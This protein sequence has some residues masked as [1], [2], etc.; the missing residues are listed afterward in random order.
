LSL[1][2]GVRVGVDVAATLL[3]VLMWARARRRLHPTW[4]LLGAAATFSALLFSFAIRPRLT[5]PYLEPDLACIALVVG[6]TAGTP[7]RWERLFPLEA[8]ATDPTPDQSRSVEAARSVSGVLVI[9]A[10]LVLE[11]LFTGAVVGVP[12]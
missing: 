12:A 11:L 1:G 6:M 10:Y 8:R 7:G 9:A 3:A 5:G 4:A 2:E